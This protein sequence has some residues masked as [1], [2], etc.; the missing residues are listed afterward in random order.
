MNHL[1][2]TLIEGVIREDAVFYKGVDNKEQCAFGIA[3]TRCY[4]EGNDLRKQV[5]NFSVR[6]NA[7]HLVEAARKYAKKGRGIRAVGRLESISPGDT[8][9]EAEHVEYR[10]EYV[11]KAG[12]RNDSTNKEI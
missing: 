12:R 10:S 11:K 2:S 1:N 3:S 9:I 4:Q 8:W 7:P 5:C 6:F